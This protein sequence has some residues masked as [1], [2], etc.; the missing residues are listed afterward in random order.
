MRLVIT[1]VSGYIGT[2]LAERLSREVAVA[3]MTGLDARPLAAPIAKLAFTRADVR[4]DDLAPHFAGV[5]VAVHLAFIVKEIRDKRLTYDINVGGTRRVLEACR[6]ARVRKLVLA[7][8]VAAYGAV[9]GK[10]VLTEA[11]PLRGDP[12]S[13]YGHT[14]RLVEEMLDG[15]E[16]ENPRMI[17]TRLRPSIL[18]GSR[19]G[20]FLTALTSQRALLHVRGNDAGLPLV[21]EDDVVDAFCRVILADHPGSFNLHAGC[22]PPGTAARMLGVPSIGVP[23]LVARV[24]SDLAFRCGALPFSGHWVTLGRYPMEISTDKARTELGWRPTRTPEEAFAEMLATLRP[25]HAGGRNG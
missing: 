2:L 3:A 4:T 24:L 12:Q 25:G 8:S 1:G 19:T 17:V 13:Y 14:K 21:H 23:Y 18:C 15:F 11:T 9:P 20:S 22:L 7:S 6:A 16:R 5:D 10:P